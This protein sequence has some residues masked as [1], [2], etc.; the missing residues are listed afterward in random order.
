M[1]FYFLFKA[2]QIV[3]TIDMF[4][5]PIQLSYNNNRVNK[6]FLGGL[7]S[8][9]LL[10]LFFALFFQALL[11]IFRKS[12]IISYSNE[13]YEPNPPYIDLNS[14]IMKWAISI[15]PS[16]MKTK[17]L[18][19][20]FKIEIFLISQFLDGNG[21]ILKN[22]TLMNLMPCDINYFN[23][24]IKKNILTLNGNNIS[25]WLCPLREERYFVQ[26]KPSNDYFSYVNIKFS[27]CEN[28]S[29]IQCVSNE[30]IDETFAELNNRMIFQ[31]FFIN[32]MIN[33]NN[34]DQPITN[35]LDDRISLSLN[36]KQYRERTYYFTK[37]SVFNDVS[38]LQTDFQ[39]FLTTFTYENNYDDMEFELS[40]EN[41]YFSIYLRSNFISKQHYRTFEKVG[42][43][44]SFIGGVW[45]VFYMF[46]SFIGRSYNKF[47][48]YVKLANDMF[49]F[50]DENKEFRK[51]IINFY[52]KKRRDLKTVNFGV[53]QSNHALNS[54]DQI[55]SLFL[56]HLHKNHYFK[57]SKSIKS[58]FSCLWR[59][60]QQRS[61]FN[62][63]KYLRKEA[64]FEINKDLDVAALLQK[65][66]EIDKLKALILNP[67][68]RILFEIRNKK[69]ISLKKSTTLRRMSTEKFKKRLL[70]LNLE[71]KE[72]K[73]KIVNE[74]LK[75]MNVY[76][77][78][79]SAIQDD[80][81]KMNEIINGKILNF[82]DSDLISLFKQIKVP[83][84]SNQIIKSKF[85]E[86][87]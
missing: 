48:L 87:S 31:F 43:F 44:I 26:G 77:E 69:K 40:D 59:K 64:F 56:G 45:S 7:N 20:Y 36:R 60:G 33:I 49:D 78:A 71:K 70:K 12:N 9:V 41:V 61:M 15:N 72:K 54:Q 6:S 19:Q 79:F 38:I 23:N 84:V 65:L 67:N 1:F 18:E 14:E 3:K 27:K 81:S 29:K 42:K 35:F 57:L 74:D 5:E 2:K 30:E 73:Q 32:Q 21:N 39:E 62:L 80:N 37:N 53:N 86:E 76:F 51:K 50:S 22:E 16:K 63:Q 10:T 68:Q 13:T 24:D 4:G 83:V 8:I 58:F 82:V 11:E 55:S 34:L 85:Y 47:R 46:F 66:H 17:R 28:S 75:E 25:T 52:Q